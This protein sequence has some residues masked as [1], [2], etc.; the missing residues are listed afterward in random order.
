[1]KSLVPA[2]VDILVDQVNS[3]AD[4]QRNCLRKRCRP[5]GKPA[6]CVALYVYRRVEYQDDAAVADSALCPGLP[7]HRLPATA[8]VWTTCRRTNAASEMNANDTTWT[9]LRRDDDSDSLTDPS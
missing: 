9:I 2:A 3:G 1:M 5:D 6:T 4:G 7:P 8:V